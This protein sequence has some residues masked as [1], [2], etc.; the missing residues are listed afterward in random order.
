MAV[1]TG[2]Q[3]LTSAAVDSIPEARECRR[4]ASG[5]PRGR[6]WRLAHLLRMAD[7]VECAMTIVDTPPLR[8]IHLA[9]R[10]AEA[11]V[12]ELFQACGNRITTIELDLTELI[13]VDTVG[14]SAL[15]SLRNGGASLR[16]VPA[17]IQLKLDS[18][19][20]KKRR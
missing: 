20:A 2:R 1:T 19:A 9:G 13:S 8:C 11:Q 16:G 18:L 10:L 14:L 5:R 15:H 3:G 4:S 17:Y 6:E 7:G 12:P